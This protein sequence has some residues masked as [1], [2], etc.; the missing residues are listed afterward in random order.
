VYGADGRPQI[1]IERGNTVVMSPQVRTQPLDQSIP[2]IPYEIV[3]AFMSKPTVVSSEDARNLPH[4]VAY[5]EAR[6]VGATGDTLYGRGV[7]GAPGTRYAL[8]H[9]AD[10]LRDPD[11][12]ASLGYMGVYT[13]MARVERAATNP[14][15]RSDDEALTKLTVV[16]S[17]RE[18]LAGDRLVAERVDVPLD[19]VP[20]APA[21][22]V[23]G[24]IIAVHDGVY[25]IGQYQ[26]VAINRG[27][28]HGLEPGHVLTIWQRGERVKD[29]G[30]ARPESSRSVI[31][32]FSNSVQ[33]PAERAGNLMVFR[34]YDRMSYA[35]VLTAETV[36]RVGDFV[37]N[38]TTG[39]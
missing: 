38:P 29:Y 24:R 6:I 37:R 4:V 36:M 14:E 16:E 5:R 35:L 11:D 7:D 12:G 20:H 34:A 22:A 1:R 26:V 13:G 25:S 27:K 19:F 28:K 8:V 3:A 30:P 15:S 2:A 31:R 21:Q 9:L 39:N 10:K 32:N 33:L 23:D 18:T 17:A